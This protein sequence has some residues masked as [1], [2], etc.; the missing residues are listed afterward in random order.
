MKSDKRML[1]AFV[2]AQS[3]KMYQEGR[4]ATVR[5]Y[6][7]AAAR[8][9]E[10]L[11]TQDVPLQRLNA[12]TVEGFNAHLRAQGLR[13]NT[14]SF[15]NRNLRA[16]LNRAKPG[17]GTALFKTVFTGN[18]RTLKRA[19]PVGT[20]RALKTKTQLKAGIQLAKDLFLFSLYA[21]G[22]SF[23]DLVYLKPENVQDSHLV[24]TRRKTGRQILVKLTP[25]MQEILA[26]YAPQSRGYLFPFLDDHLSPVQNYGRY[27]SALTLYNRRLKELGL[28]LT[29]YVARH[30]W[31]SVAYREVGSPVPVISAALGH[32]SERTTR[33]YLAGLDHR[34]VEALQENVQ[35][36]LAEKPEKKKSLPLGKRQTPSGKGNYNQGN[37]QPLLE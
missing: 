11:G 7:Q 37:K 14:L 10:Y 19:V 26:R 25:A 1:G 23:V 17:W 29:S 28:S 32:S 5:H 24:Y 34:K 36:I 18:D 35:K 27:C 31:A 2:H 21:C 3:G 33:I 16:L 15:Y 12:A 8:L 6:E 30:T 20:V 22:I 13:P 4:Y 9:L